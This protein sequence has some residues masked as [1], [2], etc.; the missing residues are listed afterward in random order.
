MEEGKVSYIIKT[1]PFYIFKQASLSQKT[2][3]VEFIDLSMLNR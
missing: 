3:S 1:H 2:F